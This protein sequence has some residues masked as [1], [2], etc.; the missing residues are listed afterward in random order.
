MDDVY[1][2]RQDPAVTVWFEL[3]RAPGATPGTGERVLAWTTTPWTLP[4]NLALAVG[5]DIEYA[6]LEQTEAD[7]TTYRY[8]LARRAWRRTRRSS[9]TPSRSARVLGSEL[10]GRRYVPLFPFFA[11]QDNAFLVL[12]A[13]FVTTEDGT[14]VVHMSPGHGEDDQNVCNAAGIRTVVPMDEHGRYTAEVA[15][16]AGQHVFDANPLVIRE[17]KER[18]RVLRHETFDHPYP[19]CWRCAQPLVYRAISSWFVQVTAFRDRM[20]ELNEPIRWVPE[21]LKDGSFGKWLANARD[22]SISRNRFWGSPIPVWKSDD[23]RYPRLDVYGSLGG[24][25][26]ATSASRSVTSTGPRWTSSCGPTR[27]I[28]PADRRCAA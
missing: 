8:V 1:R 4:S 26:S 2:D 10:V 17:L 7:G 5:P 18:G 20:V 25:A 13:D 27:T 16:W 3:E 22:W 15:P 12:A 19:H 14:G 23:P 6:V 11:D 21:H 9:A 28:R 24:A